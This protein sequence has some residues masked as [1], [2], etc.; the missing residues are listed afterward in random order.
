ME[1]HD[2][3]ENGL[4]LVS[5]GAV[6]CD[7][8][9]SNLNFLSKPKDASKDGATSHS[10]LEVVDFGAWF[11]DVKG[12]DDDESRVRGKVPHRNRDPLDDVFIDGVDI[13]F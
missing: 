1:G 4:A 5:P 10:A 7:N 2:S 11:I 13:V 12:T 6:F 8:T 3:A 9:G